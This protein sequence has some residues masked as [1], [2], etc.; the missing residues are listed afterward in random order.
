LVIDSYYFYDDR[1]NLTRALQIDFLGDGTEINTEQMNFYTDEDQIYRR[2]QYKNSSLVSVQTTTY[3]SLG[4]KARIEFMSYDPAYSG[5]S[6]MSYDP[7]NRLI[8]SANYTDGVHSSSSIYQYPGEGLDRT[9]WT[10][11]GQDSV[12]WLQ[13]EEDYMDNRIV[14][15]SS[16]SAVDQ[17]TSTNK[18]YYN[19]NGDLWKETFEKNGN[20]RVRIEKTFYGLLLMEYRLYEIDFDSAKDDY[21]LTVY[22]YY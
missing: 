10:Y 6:I 19:E 12:L 15:R 7:S 16:F 18:Y 1:S 13:G 9:F 17:D 2:E 8:R 21:Y 14:T 5:E 22:E 3:T 11:A 4:K 20:E